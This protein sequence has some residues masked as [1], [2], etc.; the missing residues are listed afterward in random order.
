MAKVPVFNIEGLREEL[1]RQLD[2]ILDQNQTDEITTDIQRF[3]GEFV[4]GEGFLT[5]DDV[6]ISG[7]SGGVPAHRIRFKL[8]SGWILDA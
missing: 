2:S 6:W 8:T 7:V 4:E 1:H 5:E 3:N